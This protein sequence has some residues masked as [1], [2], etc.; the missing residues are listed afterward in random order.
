MFQVDIQR[1]YSAKSNRKCVDLWTK[2]TVKA[3]KKK[4]SNFKLL[5]VRFLYLIIIKNKG[6][7]VLFLA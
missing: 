6:K 3:I 2:L 5:K 1:N 4:A 7:Y